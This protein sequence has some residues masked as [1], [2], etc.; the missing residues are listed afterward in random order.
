MPDPTRRKHRNGT[1][2]IGDGCRCVI[3]PVE[4]RDG[5]TFTPK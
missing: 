5:G 1:D 2:F 4:N 3:R